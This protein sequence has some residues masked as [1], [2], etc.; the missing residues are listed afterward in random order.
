MGG[1]HQDRSGPWKESTKTGVVHGRRA[2]RQE[3]SMGGE[4]Q[5]S[6]TEGRRPEGPVHGFYCWFHNHI[7]DRSSNM[8]SKEETVCSEKRSCTNTLTEKKSYFY[9]E[10]ELLRVQPCCLSLDV[11]DTL[12]QWLCRPFCVVFTST[13]IAGLL[14]VK[15]DNKQAA[16][17][18]VQSPA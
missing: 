16:S 12:T 9:F 6:R 17:P 2:P 7:L 11:F 10:S 1:E 13:E 18:P 4:H 15:G 5:D 14:R 8:G 3:W